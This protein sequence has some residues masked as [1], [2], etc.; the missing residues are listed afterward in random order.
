[1]GREAKSFR[2]QLLLIRERFPEKEIFNIG[3]VMKLTKKSRVFVKRHIMYDCKNI[4]T[5]N[6][7][8]RLCEL[9]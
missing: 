9:K 5:A 8:K 2:E 3:E 1:M 7:A 6:L 4:C